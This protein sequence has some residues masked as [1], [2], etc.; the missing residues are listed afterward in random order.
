M[1]IITLASDDTHVSIAADQQWTNDT[2]TVFYKPKLRLIYDGSTVVG[3]IATAGEE[4]PG[5]LLEDKVMDAVH[6]WFLE[7][8]SHTLKKLNQI[9]DVFREE[10]KDYTPDNRLCEAVAVLVLFGV[11]YRMDDSWSVLDFE[12]CAAGCGALVA[13]GAMW[14]MEEDDA[15]TRAYNA[16]IAACDLVSGCGG[17]IDS[18]TMLRKG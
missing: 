2:G 15:E 14:A 6:S 7:D 13:M 3:A 4:K 17:Q 11:G 1:T 8:D 18:F 12:T 5:L 10:Q 16:C 9:M